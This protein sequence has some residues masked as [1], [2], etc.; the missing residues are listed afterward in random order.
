MLKYFP[1]HFIVSLLFV[2]GTVCHGQAKDIP[3]EDLSAETAEKI[4]DF[5]TDFLY[6]QDKHFSQDFFITASAD[7]EVSIEH[8]CYLLSGQD[9]IQLYKFSYSSEKLKKGISTI[10]VSFKDP[11]TQSYLEPGFAEAIR[12]TGLI[13]V[14]NYRQYTSIRVKGHDEQYLKAFIL[15]KDSLIDIHSSVRKGI[16]D[17]LDP[18]KKNNFLSAQTQTVSASLD[19]VTHAFER[20]QHRLERYFKQKKL[21]PKQYKSGDKEIIDLYYGSWYMGRYELAVNGTLTSQL[22]R[23]KDAL[24]SNIG[25]FAHNN[26]GDYQSLLSQFRD[27]KKKSRENKELTGEIAVSANYASDQEQFSKQENQYYEARGSIEF[28]LFDIPITVSGYYTTQDKNRK[29]KASYVH[30]RYDAE[31]AKEQLLKLIGSYNA[32]YEQTITQGGNYDMIYGQFV[33]QLQQQKDQALAS[34]KQQVNIPDMDF[35]SLSEEQMKAVLEQKLL[36]EKDKLQNKVQDSIMNTAGNSDAAKGVQQGLAKAQQAKEKGQKAYDKAMEQYNKIMELERKIRKYKSMLEQYRNTMQYDSLLAYD[37]V[38]DLKNLD[39]LS[40]KDI[41][42]KASGLLP[43][44]KAKGL[45]TGLTNLDAGIFPKYVSDYTLSGQMLKGIDL[46]YDIGFAN[47]GGSYGKTEYID[48]EGHVEGYTAYSGRVQFKPILHQQLGFVYYGYS[49]GKKLLGDNDFFK[50]ASVSLPSFRNP[51]HILSLTYNGDISQYL[52]ATGEFATSNKPGQSEEAKSQLSFKER[53]AYNI[54]LEGTIPKTGL[55]LEA[56]YE[57]A[58]KAFENNTLPMIMA[59][60]ERYKIKGKGD[61]FRSFLTVGVEYNYLIQN[62]FYSKSNNSKWGFE[63]ATHSKRYPSVSLSYKPFSTFRSFTDTLNI[64]QK[65]ILGEVWTGKASYQIKKQN[66]AI[67]FNLLYNRNTSIMDTIRY[68][69]HLLQ[70]STIYS[71]KTTMLSVNI[72]SSKINTDYIE[73]T[74]PAFNNSTFVNLA[75][76]GTVTTGLS[77]TGG[78]DVASSKA[79]LSRYG[80]F[81]GSSYS[82]KKL[83]VMIRANF[84]YSNYRL[85][86]AAGWKPLYSGGIELAWRFKVKLFDD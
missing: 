33:Q 3:P 32:R 48:R 16:V 76:G 85:E 26:L 81:A 1:F 65:P 30:F 63:I 19:N 83:P 70:F 8:R 66:R 13:P 51:V 52:H 86:E 75:A 10:T 15:D 41:A 11:K 45:I 50:D 25:A 21:T 5:R 67:R 77:L 23:E 40:Y 84:R 31:K 57:H 78:I 37:K 68:G 72:G 69:S 59:G 29:A 27:I 7:C 18:V 17:I 47:V 39:Q 42:K 74:Y 55:Q 53:S 12:N 38:K 82:F 2:G 71:R 56:G 4:K 79:G 44:S 6:Q 58:G 20:N 60:T 14:G 64:E 36:E 61:F 73:I 24:E 49:P 34:L 9:S 35:S 80:C 43:E 62:S 46:G 22:K 54:R 28:P